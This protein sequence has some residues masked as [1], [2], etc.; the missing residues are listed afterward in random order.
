MTQIEMFAEPEARYPVRA[1]DITVVSREFADRIY[2][3]YGQITRD[4]LQF[5]IELYTRA[6][7]AQFGVQ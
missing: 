3:D 2:D 6:A 1:P 5:R 4:A 7:L